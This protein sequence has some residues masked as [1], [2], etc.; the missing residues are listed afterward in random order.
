MKDFEWR[1]RVLFEKSALP[2]TPSR[3]N[4]NIYYF[5]L[6]VPNLIVY[7]K[8]FGGEHENPFFSKKG[9]LA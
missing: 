3:K 1:G 9:V 5:D 6:I 7:I 8:A 4:F 2:R